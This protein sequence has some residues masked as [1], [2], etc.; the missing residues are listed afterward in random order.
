MSVRPSR[1]GRCACGFLR[2]GALGLA[3]ALLL[4]GPAA[5]GAVAAGDAQVL[6]R[7]AAI[8]ALKPATDAAGL[9]RYNHLMD[10][11]WQYFTAHRKE[12]LPTLRTELARELRQR[13]PND[14]L[15]LDVGYFLYEQHDD[16]DLA[17][18]A[19]FALDPEA[20]MVRINSQ[21]L[22]YFAHAV[23][24][25][26]D[27]RILPFIG[28]VFRDGDVSVA[29]PARKLTL[30][31]TLLCAY[32]YGVYGPDGES[33]LA[34]GLAD[35]RHRNRVLET[36]IWM[37]S[38]ASD[39]AVRALLDEAPDYETFTRATTFLMRAGGPKGRNI[40]LA[41]DPAAL[42]ARS[43]DFY[44]QLR[45]SIESTSLATLTENLA[46]FGPSAP[47]K[48]EALEAELTALYDSHGDLSGINPAGL[49][50]APLPR[51]RL[52]ERLVAI[53]QR[54]FYRITPQ[55]LNDIEI[56]D[57]VINALHYRDG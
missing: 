19:L 52:V 22:F 10:E 33:A 21:E 41:L 37:G 24:A 50:E 56:L 16:L 51:E 47:I 18:R 48:P 46:R 55:G 57:A 20:P 32:L 11:S 1:G 9:E 2:H 26:H 53:R 14:L 39:D 23:A 49:L 4:A 42:D 54:G 25:D 8:R 12:S 45:G 29:I 13:R 7:L 31:D 44:K 30:G 40:L 28:R 38:P 27:A 43:Q 36:L 35:P 15:L 5:R 6:Q 34:A 3:L 17:K